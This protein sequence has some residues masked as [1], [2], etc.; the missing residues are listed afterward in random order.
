MEATE[1]SFAVAAAELRAMDTVCESSR[2]ALRTAWV[3]A[4]HEGA[5]LDAQEA[6]LQEEFDRRGEAEALKLQAL[7]EQR[8]LLANKMLAELQNEARQARDELLTDGVCTVS[9]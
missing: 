1:Q 3:T 7:F 6:M 2:T 8:R 9:C 5:D 4:I